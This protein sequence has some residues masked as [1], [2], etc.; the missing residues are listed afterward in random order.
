MRRVFVSYR[1][2]DAE[3]ADAL[4]DCVKSVGADCYLDQRDPNLESI[5]VGAL[6]RRTTVVKSIRA[7]MQGADT[8]VAVITRLARGSWWVPAEVAIALEMSKEVVAICETDV[9][10]PDFVVHHLIL[11]EP[12][13][14]TWLGGLGNRPVDEKRLSGFSRDVFKPATDSLRTASRHA[15]E[16]IEALW[17]PATWNDLALEDPDYAHRGNWIGCT[18]ETLISTLR[19][20]AVPVYLWRQPRFDRS[21]LEREV[22]STLFESWIDEESLAALEPRL[23]YEARKCRDW[24]TLR[25]AD[26]ARYWLQGMKLKDLDDL[27]SEISSADGSPIS[28]SALRDLFLK[29]ARTRGAIQKALGLAA[30]ALQGFTLTKRPVFARVLAVHLRIHH[31]L[32]RLDWAGGIGRMTL[33]QLFALPPESRVQ[34][35]VESAA[36]LE[37]LMQKRRARLQPLLWDESKYATVPE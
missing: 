8:L 31:A 11:D 9:R 15:V 37:Y 7:G 33:E 16:R 3:K 18:S 32:L 27:F 4:A 36:S 34:G 6:E 10:P 24:R 13:L 35:T 25:D 26:P 28:E 22:A 14:R 1:S 29:R 12:H 17:D 23:L 19:A 30:N 5:G 2:L 21:E 20:I